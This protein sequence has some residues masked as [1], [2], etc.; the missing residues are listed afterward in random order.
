MR[1]RPPIPSVDRSFH[2]TRQRLARAPI[3]LAVATKTRTS[4]T[5]LSGRGQLRPPRDRL[6]RSPDPTCRLSPF[7]DR[8]L[9]DDH[10]MPN[11]ARPGPRD[12]GLGP[13][14]GARHHCVAVGG[15]QQGVADLDTCEAAEE[16]VEEA[17]GTQA[18]TK[19]RTWWRGKGSKPKERR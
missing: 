4:D 15:E 14:P 5:V 7:L 11:L 12:L 10:V 16:Q 3:L 8:P 19:D 17:T 13:I 1:I 18:W 6:D 2:A 9:V